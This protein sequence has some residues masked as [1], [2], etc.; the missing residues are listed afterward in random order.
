M[1]KVRSAIA[2]VMVFPMLF[3]LTACSK[4]VKEYDKESFLAV[5]KDDLKIEDD[6]IYE[7]EVDE[8]NGVGDGVVVAARHGHAMITVQF[9][10]DAAD[11]KKAF[12]KD[13]E[14]FLDTFNKNDQ[15]KGDYIAE[16]TSNGGYI[17]IKGSAPE[18][19]IFGD[20]NRT[21][22]VY[23]G[24][25][26]SGSMIMLVMSQSADD[27]DDVGEIISALGLPNV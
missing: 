20:R 27:F 19:D 10:D 22:D 14:S 16:Q 15:F 18:T 6:D 5:L 9:C 26:C 23:G 3:S 12:D 2:L 11:A 21:G 7:T 13:Y 8:H 1:R 25:Y 17:V 24:Y 4:S